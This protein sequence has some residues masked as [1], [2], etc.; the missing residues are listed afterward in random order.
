VLAGQVAHFRDGL[1]SGVDSY[2][3]AKEAFAAVGLSE[4]DVHRDSS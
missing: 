1:I 3:D 4:L 2:Y